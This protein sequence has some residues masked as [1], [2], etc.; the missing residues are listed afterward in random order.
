L[1]VVSIDEIVVMR[2]TALLLSH[3]LHC[4][5]CRHTTTNTNRVKED[6][7]VEL[8]LSSLPL[9]LFLLSSCK[10][11]FA[12]P[13]PTLVPRLFYNDSTAQPWSILRPPKKAYPLTQDFVLFNLMCQR[14]RLDFVWCFRGAF[15]PMAATVV[16]GEVVNRKI[17]V[18]KA[19]T[20]LSTDSTV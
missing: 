10:P 6:K 2:R 17:E 13:P 12:T 19:T 1:I 8:L 9:P 15:P 7:T 3:Q 14:S 20:N 16:G 5:Y 11:P 18:K 4:Q